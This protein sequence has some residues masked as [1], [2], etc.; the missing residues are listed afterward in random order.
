MERRLCDNFKIVYFVENFEFRL[1]GNCK[2]QEYCS[3]KCKNEAWPIH[4]MVCKSKLRFLSDV[5]TCDANRELRMKYFLQSAVLIHPNKIGY[6]KQRRIVSVINFIYLLSL[7][8]FNISFYSFLSLKIFVIWIR[9]F[10][11][12]KIDICGSIV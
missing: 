1:C 4:K 10:Y 2:N 8:W 12:M 3:N 11:H 7:Q 6:I 9:Q 5:C